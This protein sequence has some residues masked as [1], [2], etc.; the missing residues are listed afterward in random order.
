[1]IAMGG[2]RPNG[3]S[4]AYRLD[5]EHGAPEKPDPRRDLRQDAEIGF[6]APTEYPRLELGSA[7]LDDWLE[8]D[9]Q[10]IS[11][12]PVFFTAAYTE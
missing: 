9:P 5:G 12:V 11:F 7:M 3:E 8:D 2:V 6:P 1:M 4:L 10:A